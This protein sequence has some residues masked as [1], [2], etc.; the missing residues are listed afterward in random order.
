MAVNYY[1]FYG[2]TTSFPTNETK[3]IQIGEN[4][5]AGALEYIIVR[6]TATVAT[7]G[8]VADFP[9]VFSSIRFT[10]NGNVLHDFRQA[11]SGGSNNNPS[12]YGYFLNA[13][14]GKSVEKPSDLSKEW[15]GIIPIGQQVQSGV[16]RLEIS[17]DYAAT[18]AAASAGSLQIWGRYNEACQTT[19][20]VSPSTSF[21]HAASIETVVVRIPQNVPGAVGGI[22]VQ[23][24]SAADEYGSQGLRLLSQ[25]QFGLDADFLRLFNGDLSN[26]VM[27]GDDDLSTTQ[28]TYAQ[29]VPG[30]L[31]VP[32]YNLRGGDVTLNVD[33]SAATTRTYTPVIIAPFN[34]KEGS[35][36]KQT[37]V[38]AGNTSKAI[39]DKTVQ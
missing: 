11:V 39:L 26:G 4:I 2:D 37:A 25:S 19:T 34:A 17:I 28:L 22:L 23:N 10:L 15:Y 1:K 21:Q 5:P 16:G 13:I 36:T 20:I 8:I 29:E 7:G 9:N 6:C 14:G 38:V 27:Y 33:S 24:D 30:S 3:S 12:A 18:A 31:F 35:G 32:A